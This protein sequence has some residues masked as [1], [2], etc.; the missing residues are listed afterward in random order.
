MLVIVIGYLSYRNVLRLFQ[1]NAQVVEA[2]EVLAA[3]AQAD[4]AIQ[5][6]QSCAIS[7]ALVGD[8]GYRAAATADIADAKKQL[9]RLRVLTQ[10]NASQQA[11]LNRLEPQTANVF[12]NFQQVAS[13][14]W[15]RASAAALATDLLLRE[16]DTLNDIR[17]S[18]RAMQDE[19]LLALGRYSAESAADTRSTAFLIVL[20]NVLALIVLVT[21]AVALHYDISRRVK[22]E[23][24]LSSSERQYRTLF[25]NA[26]VGIYRTTP[27][28][29]ILAANP[30]LVRM[31]GFSSFEELARR[32]LN[33]SG[34]EPQNARNQF[35][36]RL[37]NAGEVAGLESAWRRK[38]GEAIHVRENSRAIRDDS[39]QVL[40]YEGTVEDITQRKREQAEHA[41]LVTAIEQFEE[42]V[43]ITN[44]AGDIEYV[45]PAFTR[46]T[47]YSREEVLGKNPRILKSDR[48]DPGFY[49]QLWGTILKGQTWQGELINRRKD[50]T[51]VHR[52]DEYRPGPRRSRRDHRLYRHQ[53]GCDRAQDTG[54]TASTSGED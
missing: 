19:E 45:N 40:Y 44:T 13:H 34:F 38:N 36:E 5:S 46:M 11:L 1:V 54:S 47:G 29:H 27:G 10:H 33:T 20:R 25:E 51:P 41:R 22:A 21:V 52:A 49:R 43:V 12:L 32:N 17:R 50:G 6:A 35:M 39:G 26:P 2:H 8:E 30:A 14:P 16:R 31:L 7:F 48:Q 53:T 24:A 9:D 37:E 4:R 18:M 15:A 28:G 23:K 42:A 3:I